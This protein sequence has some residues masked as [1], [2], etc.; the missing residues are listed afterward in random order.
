MTTPGGGAAGGS[1]DLG[2]VRGKIIIDSSEAEKGAEKAADAVDGFTKKAKASNDRAKRDAENFATGYGLVVAGGIALA[3]NAAK[4]FEQA[5]ANVAAA[6]GKDAA[7]QMDAVR[8]KALQLGADTKFSATEAA[9]AM[10]VLI[11]AGLSVEDVLNGA[12]DAAVNLAAAEG[13]TIPE[14]AEIA[15]VAMTAFNLKAQDMPA[16]AN[17]ISQ[18]A[19]ATK[20]DVNDFSHAM[21]QAGAVSKL[22]GLSFDDM[23]LA[24]VAMGKAGIVGS[25]AGTSLKTMLMNLQPSTKAARNAMHDLGLITEDGQNK[26]FNARGE[27]K[28]M[29]E[30]SELLYQATRKLTPAQRQMALETIFGS[31][32]IRAAAIISEQGATGMNKLTTEMSNQLSVADKAKVKQDTLAGS[33]EKMKGSIETAAIQFGTVF[34][35][36]LRDIAEWLEKVANWFAQLPGP[37]KEA[38][39][40]FAIITAGLMAFGL[41]IGFIMKA[42]KGLTAVFNVLKLALLGHPILL[43]AAI[44]AAAVAAIIV[45]WEHVE[46]ALSASWNF[47]KNLAITVWTAVKDFFVGTFTDIKNWFVG[48][49]TDIKEWFG[50]I[51]DWFVE[52]AGYNLTHSLWDQ[53]NKYWTAIRDFAVR[54]WSSITGDIV[55]TWTGFTSWISRT[56]DDLGAWFGRTWTSLRDGASRAFSDVVNWF[57]NLPGDIARSLGSAGVHLWNW[58]RDMIVGLWD[59]IKAAWNWLKTNVGNLISDLWNFIKNRLGIGSPSKIS[60]EMGEWVTIG[61][62]KGVENKIDVL[63]ASLNKAGALIEPTLAPYVAPAATVVAGGTARVTPF[64]PIAGTPSGVQGSGGTTIVIEK[65]EIP[66]NSMLDPTDPVQWRKAMVTIKDGINNIER[67]YGGS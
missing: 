41:A 20:M 57:S 54:I 15:A 38:I 61:L 34:I 5:L 6:G 65:L 32:A 16:I 44:I 2:T 30:I 24:I 43:I 7:N 18:A 51:V 23:T 58:G 55:A 10:E 29:T 49:W 56:L 64:M 13:I 8:A 19:S 28:S 3:V 47:L 36:V 35:P 42:V 59:G 31:D 45:N 26:F 53:I 21:N 48:I 62:G 50:G 9:A 67:E 46:K 33:I 4:D 37:V 66:I 63:M 11:K 12:A 52:D 17:K 39:A 1:G 27:I 40:W 22:V 25:D 14:A 60:F